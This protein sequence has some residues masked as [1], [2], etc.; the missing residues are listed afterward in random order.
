[1]PL[2]MLTAREGRLSSSAIRFAESATGRAAS[3][4][5]PRG[6]VVVCL[7]VDDSARDDVNTGES[8]ALLNRR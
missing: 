3:L 4:K 1:M 7:G 8:A 5:S 2:L 6:I